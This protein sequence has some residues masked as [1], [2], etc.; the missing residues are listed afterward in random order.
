MSTPTPKRKRGQHA[1]RHP[2]SKLAYGSRRTMRDAYEDWVVSLN[3]V[4][5]IG[6]YQAFMAGYRAGK[7][8]K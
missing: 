6:E 1:K 5:E 8:A 4:D 2:W 3:D 7:D